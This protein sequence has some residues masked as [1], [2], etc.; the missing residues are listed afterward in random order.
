MCVARHIAH[1]LTARSLVRVPPASIAQDGRIVP[2]GYAL[3]FNLF[4]RSAG[5]LQLPQLR[6]SDSRTP[7]VR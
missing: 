4:P 3:G 7:T 5:L 1:A 6:L 2:G